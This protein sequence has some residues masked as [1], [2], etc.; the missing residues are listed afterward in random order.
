LAV[1]AVDL[2]NILS[3]FILQKLSKLSLVS[4]REARTVQFK[5]SIK[6]KTS[7][8]TSFVL[9]SIIAQII[10]VYLSLISHT[11]Y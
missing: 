6:R 9:F 4:L 3:V 8:T 11:L 10:R 7:L 1:S 5:V 2:E